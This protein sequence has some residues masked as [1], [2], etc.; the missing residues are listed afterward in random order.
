MRILYFH[1][2]EIIF[3]LICV[4]ARMMILSSSSRI[5]AVIAMAPLVIALGFLFWGALLFYPTKWISNIY[6]KNRFGEGY[7][8][9]SRAF[10]FLVGYYA[11]GVLHIFQSYLMVVK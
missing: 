7:Q 8:K 10:C 11:F 2:N 6:L 3:F 9:K 1:K 5:P 4:A